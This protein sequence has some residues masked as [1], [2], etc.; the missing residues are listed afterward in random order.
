[1]NDNIASI[2]D[3]TAGLE[4][5]VTGTITKVPHTKLAAKFLA[6]AFVFENPRQR[7]SVNSVTWNKHR[8]TPSQE[9]GQLIC[10]KQENLTSSLE[11]QN[12]PV[13]WEGVK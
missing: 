11:Q 6:S 4:R 2:K 5:D 9:I 7:Y 12:R 1:M 3:L 13:T 10:L 8:R